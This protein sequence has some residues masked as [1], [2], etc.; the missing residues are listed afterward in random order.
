MAGK[1]AS[2]V[3]RSNL[4]NIQ[5]NKT[6]EGGKQ[7]VYSTDLARRKSN[8]YALAAGSLGSWLLRIR[9]GGRETIGRLGM[10]RPLRR[11]G[12]K[13]KREEVEVREV[14]G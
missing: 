2:I 5:T 12:G 1:G 3:Y 4:Q 14:G 8:P 9:R 13:K 7:E 6:E 10:L 11:G